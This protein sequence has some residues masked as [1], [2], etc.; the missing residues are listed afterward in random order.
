MIIKQQISRHSSRRFIVL[1]YYYTSHHWRIMV[2]QVRGCHS[3]EFPQTTEPPWN[4]AVSSLLPQCR[5]ATLPEATQGSRKRDV[6]P[7][8]P[9]H[10]PSADVMTFCSAVHQHQCQSPHDAPST[11]WPSEQLRIDLRPAL[12]P[13]PHPRLAS[14]LLSW[15]RALMHYFFASLSIEAPAARKTKSTSSKPVFT[16]STLD[17]DDDADSSAV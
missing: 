17:G 1:L 16:T 14:P 11:V 2:M 6:M 9:S 12:L 8:S 15:E 3:S 5:P 4:K 7:K 13:L 10:K